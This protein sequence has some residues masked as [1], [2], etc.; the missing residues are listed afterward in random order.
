M[1][2]ADRIKTDVMTEIVLKHLPAWV[3][4][5]LVLS[6]VRPAVQGSAS[7]GERKVQRVPEAVVVV[8]RAPPTVQIEQST[9]RE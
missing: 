3:C 5:V 4:S 8:P 6:V 9:A 7:L 2:R 1:L